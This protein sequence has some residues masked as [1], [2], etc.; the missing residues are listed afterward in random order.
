MATIQD[1]NNPHCIGLSNGMIFAEKLINLGK[2]P[3]RGAFY[4]FLGIK[5]K[6]GTGAPGR[7]IAIIDK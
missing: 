1:D 6:G 5:V 3:S 4:I 2:L 7:A